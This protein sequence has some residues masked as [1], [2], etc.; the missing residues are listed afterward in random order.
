MNRYDVDIVKAWGE[1]VLGVSPHPL[2]EWVKYNEVFGVE[3]RGSV[4]YHNEVEEAFKSLVM[5]FS[6]VL[7]KALPFYKIDQAFFEIAQ[8]TGWNYDEHGEKRGEQE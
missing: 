3:N 4:V 2:G 5:N 1:Q 7:Y 8:K 6:L